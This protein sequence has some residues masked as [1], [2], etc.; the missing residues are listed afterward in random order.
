MN[1]INNLYDIHIHTSPDVKLRKLDDVE[2]AK[3]A[4]ESG[5]KGFSI[6]NHY[7][8][9]SARA[10]LLTK[11]FPDIIVYGGVTL[12]KSVGG[13]NKFAVKSS[14]EF[15]GKFVWLPTM[16]S[17][18]YNL[19]QRSKNS[20]YSLG[21]NEDYLSILDKNN[22]LKDE[23]FEIILEAKKFGMVICSGHLSSIEGVELAKACHNYKVKMLATHA[24]NPSTKY[25]IDQQK[26][27]V[28]HG[29][30]IEYS[31]F[32][33]YKNLISINELIDNINVIGPQN[34]ILTTDLGQEDSPFPDIGLNDYVKILTQHG[35]SNDDINLMLRY[36][37]ED[38]V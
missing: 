3:R 4:I 11:Y 38:L 16:D 27:I 26:E 2:M 28:K 32:C 33:L 35:I 8:D 7:C 21:N 9:T 10:N 22:N 5:L 36:N 31:Y 24:D 30:V 19:Y 6:K 13:L 23:V 18:S 25:S 37:I 20:N 14:G 29:A 12:N 15:G 17:L 34:I 1:L